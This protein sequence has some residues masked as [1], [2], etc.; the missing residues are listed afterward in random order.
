M[1]KGRMATRAGAARAGAAV[2]SSREKTINMVLRIRTVDWFFNG[3]S[4]VYGFL[5][6]PACAGM[7]W[8]VILYK[9][10]Y[11]KVSVFLLRL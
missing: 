8:I 3:V 5:W 1:S 9:V 2:K 6:I 11:F 7:T 4:C 10:G